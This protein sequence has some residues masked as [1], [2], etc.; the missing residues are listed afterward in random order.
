MDSGCQSVQ[1]LVLERDVSVSCYRPLSVVVVFSVSDRTVDKLVHLW[2]I[3]VDVAA[4]VII[5]SRG[6][7]V[8]VVRR[9]DRD[10]FQFISG[11][12]KNVVHVVGQRKV[13]I[14]REF[15]SQF[16]GTPVTYGKA[17]LLIPLDHR[18]LVV[19]T[20]G[21]VMFCLRASAAH[22]DIVLGV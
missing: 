9:K 10:D 6:H 2:R 16:V 22:R 8:L 19:V 11:N 15:L 13:D 5:K 17:L 7:T 20:E 4:V 14:R 3:V 1:Y 12:G 18:F 21:E